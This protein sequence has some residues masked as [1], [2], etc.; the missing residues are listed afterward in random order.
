[1]CFLHR[2][3]SGYSKPDSLCYWNKV[4][5]INCV[6]EVDI[7]DKIDRRMQ[8]DLGQYARVGHGYLSFPKLTGEIGPRMHFRDK[9]V[10]CWSLNNYLG[11][12]NHPIIRQTDQE[13][14]AAYGFGSPMGSRMLTGNS[15]L[16][17][18]FEAESA[19]FVEKEDT[20]LLNF[21]YQGVV[22]II[23]TLTDRKDVIVYDQLAHACI[24]D[25]MGLS[26][27]KR[28]V[29]AHNDLAQLEDRLEKAQRIV[30]QTG[31]GILV[32][33]EGVFGMAGDMGR[34]KD[35]AALKSRYN[36][37]LMID[38]A[39]GF[40]VL[41]RT[42]IGAAEHQGVQDQVDIYFTT[43]AK[44]MAMIGAFVSGDRKVMSYLRYN[45]RSQIYAKSM[46]MP[47]V[48]GALKR[49]ELLR[50]MPELRQKLW[51]IVHAIQ[52]GLKDRGFDIGITNSPVTPVFLYGTDIEAMHLVYDLREN[53]HVFVS[54]VTY[55]VIEKGKI[56]LRIIPTAA[57]TLEDVDY[58]LNAFSAVREKLDSR[59]YVGLRPPVLE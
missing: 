48:V 29:F 3:Y 1:L 38:D 26:L 54:G 18:Q 33:T 23:Q 31:G 56:M 50:T 37:R 28:F 58:T 6:I 51:T 49:L 21:G 19:I 24:I 47:L 16:H 12:A 44:S 41:G 32:I 39:H 4:S 35:I 36:F 7:F 52:Q 59:A 42:G 14:A 40:G 5:T 22:S 13:A 8:T 15:D 55:P 25:G 45:M 11:L 27:A 53:H 57:H 17:E 9:E 10:L 46:P 20:I 30:E 2:Y 34:I 43:F